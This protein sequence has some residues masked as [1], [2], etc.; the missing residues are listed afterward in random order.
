MS[1]LFD[2]L[3]AAILVIAVGVP[4]VMLFDKWGKE[5]DEGDE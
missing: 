2:V 1:T 4:C 3:L 5:M